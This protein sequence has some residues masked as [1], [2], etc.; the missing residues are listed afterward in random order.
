MPTN[1]NEIDLSTYSY[2]KGRST[3]LEKRIL[4]NSDFLV[5]LMAQHGPITKDEANAAAMAW[6]GKDTVA[7]TYFGPQNGYVSQSFTDT[8]APFYALGSGH[9]GER[10][11]VSND[12]TTLWFRQGKGRNCTYSLNING[13]KRLAELLA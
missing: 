6:R 2:A 4:S 1:L 12:L 8:G 10:V 5:I 7:S 13:I 9:Y 3:N 11:F